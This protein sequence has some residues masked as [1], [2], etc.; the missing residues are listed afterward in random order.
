M[1][2]QYVKVPIYTTDSRKRC[3]KRC[4][5]YTGRARIQQHT[6]RRH[7]GSRET[8][9]RLEMTFDRLLC[10]RVGLV[11]LE[12]ALGK[13]TPRLISH[14][15]RGNPHTCWADTWNGNPVFQCGDWQLMVFNDCDSWDYIAGG[16]TPEGEV[17]HY[18]SVNHDR[19]QPEQILGTDEEEM[20]METAFK[21][22]RRD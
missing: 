21:K 18:E 17:F 5:N 9:G 12:V 10:A 4:L 22:A 7:P 1:P 8:G 19:Y 15:A 13:I 14:G 6:T 20:A 11:L 2:K 3:S 16:T